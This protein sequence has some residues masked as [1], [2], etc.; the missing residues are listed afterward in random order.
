[1]VELDQLL[2]QSKKPVTTIDA[3]PVDPQ[4][5]LVQPPAP[6]STD[7]MEILRSLLSGREALEK[8]LESMQKSL[9]ELK[10]NRTSRD[11]SPTPPLN[12]SKVSVSP[13]TKVPLN[14]KK[15]LINRL[16]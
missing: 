9:S 5:V 3:R 1:M 6:V 14:M 4:P 8:G 2:S 15:G 7:Q 12:N 13:K 10:E 16:K 11:T